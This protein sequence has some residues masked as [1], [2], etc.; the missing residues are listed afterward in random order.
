MKRHTHA[1]AALLTLAAAV[2]LTPTSAG[3]VQTAHAEELF[4]RPPV[5]GLE[6]LPKEKARA[7]LERARPVLAKLAKSGKDDTG[8]W[9]SDKKLLDAASYTPHVYP[10]GEAVWLVYLRHVPAEGET[11]DSKDDVVVLFD[12][13]REAA[14]L[15]RGA[16]SH[17][18][19]QSFTFVATPSGH[20]L[21]REQSNHAGGCV[22]AGGIEVWTA[23][24]GTP[25]KLEARTWSTPDN[26]AGTQVRPQPEGDLVF[27]SHEITAK[28][29]EARTVTVDETEESCSWID[30]RGIYMCVD[31]VV[32]EGQSMP[33]C[34]TH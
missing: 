24:G 10:M 31:E 15:R 1:A 8:S 30:G 32:K 28:D 29:K 6:A 13:K 7:V 34:F 23:H 20:N 25:R 11:H 12:A 16:I 9:P 4:S 19:V 5:H 14:P 2:T 21:I 18:Q 26:G 17:R 3:P 33:G 27:R 22:L